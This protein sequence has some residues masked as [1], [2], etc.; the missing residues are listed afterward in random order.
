MLPASWTTAP[1]GGHAMSM[2][3]IFIATGFTGAW[4][5]WFLGRA[6]LRK[7]GRIESKAVFFS[8]K[9]GCQEAIVKEI[10]AARG[11][12]LVQAYSFTADPLTY[13][14]IEAKKRGV[15]VELLLDKSTE[16]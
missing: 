6:A 10:K 1:S 7:L 3:W 14:L 5:L 4:T 9:G 16:M 15:H 11:E 2:M 12:I 8:P 13:G